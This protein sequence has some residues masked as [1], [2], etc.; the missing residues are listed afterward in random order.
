MPP[1]FSM[2][3][4]SA[5]R[6]RPAVSPCAAILALAVLAAGCAPRPEW[7]ALR[8]T[9]P[10]FLLAREASLPAIAA[11]GR[12]VALTWVTSNAMGK[13]LWLALS[14]DGG[15]TFAAPVRV[16]DNAGAVWA[17]E[18]GRPVPHALGGGRWLV[19]WSERRAL[20]PEAIDL[21]VRSSLPDESTLGP[22]VIVNDDVEDDHV[23]FH[24][25]PAF[26]RLSDGAVLAVWSDDR[27]EHRAG[28]DGVTSLFQASSG[29]DGATWSDNRPV[30][31][32][33]CRCCRPA[34]QAANGVVTVAYRAARPGGRDL[35]VALSR[36][37]GTNFAVHEVIAAEAAPPGACPA[38]GPAICRSSDGGA[39]VAWS[40][41]AEG[42][43]VSLAPLRERALAGPARS[44]DDS[45]GSARHPR[46]A[47]VGEGTLIALEGRA[48]GDNGR[49]VIALRLARDQGAPT[50][51]MFLGAGADQA[52][53][54]TAGDGTALVCWRESGEAARLRLVRVTPR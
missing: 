2:P 33:A 51:W 40:G 6:E 7:A 3:G 41:V 1:G 17:D 15:E 23:T 37:D 24:G 42:G 20:E 43:G 49:R 36:D 4:W 11:E 19:A 31:S 18:E 53:L 29:D 16:N 38:D 25:R 14:S 48:P 35:A 12:H 32:R 45:L 47:R 46:L 10:E 5:F 26:A 30:T 54:A 52:W 44:L 50:P 27:E 9:T 13:D 39:V 34:V 21:V 8:E 28:D 22:A